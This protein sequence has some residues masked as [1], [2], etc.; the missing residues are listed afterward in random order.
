MGIKAAGLDW[1]RVPPER[2]TRWG[3]WLR[4]K[5]GAD[6]QETV[7]RMLDKMGRPMGGSYYSE[8]ETGSAPVND[9]W[10]AVFTR[11]Y[12]ESANDWDDPWDKAPQESG[13]VLAAIRA[14]TAA[15]EAQAAA[16]REIVEEMRAARES[17]QGRS[18]G[19]AA[20][21]GDLANTLASLRPLLDGK[22]R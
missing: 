6:S 16:M 18:E 3:R 10:Q 12:G 14:L 1:G 4:V 21:L 15:T 9:D 2:R 5:R 7:L 13:D 8:M 19:M 20:A 22:S 17:T 11:A